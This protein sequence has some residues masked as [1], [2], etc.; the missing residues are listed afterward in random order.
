MTPYET[1]QREALT[2]YLHNQPRRIDPDDAD[3]EAAIVLDR[4][5][6]IDRTTLPDPTI[7]ARQAD[8]AQASAAAFWDDA[9]RA[10]ANAYATERYDRERAAVRAQAEADRALDDEAWELAKAS[11]WWMTSRDGFFLDAEQ[12]KGWRAVAEKAREL[13]APGETAEPEI[14][15]ID[16]TDGISNVKIES[17]RDITKEGRTLDFRRAV[18]ARWLLDLPETV[19][20]KFDGLQP[21]TQRAIDRI[22]ELEDRANEAEN[23][24]GVDPGQLATLLDH[25]QKTANGM[26]ETYRR[27]VRAT[28]AAVRGGFGIARP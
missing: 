28:C 18:L 17:C 26:E 12:V 9:R 3:T 10:I 16:L 20:V 19:D 13:H 1:A 7:N 8:V 2:E 15:A 11:A 21:S 27:G 24:Q 25:I 4:F 23:S 22:V 5:V 14:F 6:V